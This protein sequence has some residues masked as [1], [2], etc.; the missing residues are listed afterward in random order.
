MDFD[1]YAI[2]VR[3][4]I[5]RRKLGGALPNTQ[6]FVS[7]IEQYKHAWKRNA[8]L[9]RTEPHELFRHVVTKLIEPGETWLPYGSPDSAEL[10]WADDPSIGQ[11]LVDRVRDVVA[12]PLGIVAGGQ[13]LPDGLVPYP[14]C[15]VAVGL[16]RS[17]PL[18]CGL[19]RGD[20]S[21]DALVCEAARRAIGQANRREEQQ[22]S[23]EP[24][25]AAGGP[26]RIGDAAIVVTILHDRELLG[27]SRG[28]VAAKLRRGLDAL[29]ANE[30]DLHAA[31]LPSAIPYNNLTRRELV[32]TVGAS[33][34]LSG[35]GTQWSTFRT[36][37]WLGSGHG[38]H[39]LRFGFPLHQ[40]DVNDHSATLELLAT[41]IVAGLGP[42]GLPAYHFDPVKARTTRFG[43]SARLVSGLV[44]LGKAGRFLKRDDL[45]AASQRGL[46]H[47]LD[48]VGRGPTPG[49][50]ALPQQR[51]GI[52]ADC[53]LLEGVMAGGST[54]ADHPAVD[55]L[56]E[57]VVSLL[58]P[59][60]RI[61]LRPVRLGVEQDH[62]YLPGA[63]LL[64]AAS[65]GL[66]R[67]AAIRAETL[68]ACLRWSRGRFRVLYPWGM[69]GW[70]P[71]GWAAA[72]RLSGHDDQAQFVFEAADWAVERQ[73]AKS[74]AFLED[75]GYEEPSANTGFLA[76]GIAAAW[77]VAV[78]L[79]DTERRDRYARS[80]LQAM[81]FLTTL[82][83]LPQDTFCMAKPGRAVGG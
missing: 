25:G 59:D 82:V 9:A 5:S 76:E 81:K 24:G 22:P 65:A 28:L 71:Q 13:P 55:S 18:G 52:L 53:V 64:A 36:T 8:G 31:A 26:S 4:E 6:V 43:T 60:G 50:L 44:A 20:G 73:L 23:P 61:C 78:D 40:S 21:L 30:G 7:E 1:R 79:G 67:R 62:D 12:V 74:G 33:A 38:L 47:C 27:G 56:T 46:L 57:R 41:H 14:I 29:D 54:L 19:A 45:V 51:N 75:L 37:A 58:R 77:R 32:A 2:V 66:A 72:W 48:H 10:A 83:V 3:S 63:A 49:S 17:G 16:Y 42:D 68:E 39:R 69:A 34:G 15:G 80:W 11:A 35:R 70:Q